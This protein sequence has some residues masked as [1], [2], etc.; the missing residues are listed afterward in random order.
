[1][2]ISLK[3]GRSPAWRAG[4]TGPLEAPT[5]GATADRGRLTHH[6]HRLPDTGQPMRPV[7]ATRCHRLDL[8]QKNTGHQVPVGRGR[9][10]PVSSL[11]RKP[12][13]SPRAGFDGLAEG[14]AVALTVG[15]A[16]LGRCPTTCLPS[17]CLSK[18][19]R[20][21][22]R[23]CT[24]VRVARGARRHH[25]GTHGRAVDLTG[26]CRIRRKMQPYLPGARR[27]AAGCWVQGSAWAPLPWRIRSR[28]SWCR[29]ASRAGGR[30]TGLRRRR[31]N[32]PSTEWAPLWSPT[33]SLAPTKARAGSS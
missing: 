17:R 5:G 11:A 31:S 16:Q 2:F 20:V 25:L 23:L 1:M 15:T 24:A 19:N 18:K 13:P 27:T 29:E 8:C 28:R 9:T 22:H 12:G 32:W 3:P 26:R 6:Q 4:T 7:L 33:S 14:G 21:T 10:A 30:G